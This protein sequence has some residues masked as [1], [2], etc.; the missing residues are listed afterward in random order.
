MQ[1]DLWRRLTSVWQSHQPSIYFDSVLLTSARCAPRQPSRPPAHDDDDDDVID[2]LW[3]DVVSVAQSNW[4]CWWTTGIQSAAATRRSLTSAV[5]V[6]RL[7]STCDKTGTT[8]HRKCF[9]GGG[10]PRGTC[11]IY[12]YTGK[13]TDQTHKQHGFSPG[14]AVFQPCYLVL[15]FPVLRFPFLPLQT[16]QPNTE[17]RCRQSIISH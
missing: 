6:F 17:R 9:Q 4:R 14:T 13:V 15:H 10:W 1:T 3:D 2:D 8:A 7:T 11:S 16:M 12:I 5:V